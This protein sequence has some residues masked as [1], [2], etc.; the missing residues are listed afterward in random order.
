MQRGGR[1]QFPIWMGSRTFFAGKL[2]SDVGKEF[3]VWPKFQIQSIGQCQRWRITVSRDDKA[4]SSTVNLWTIWRSGRNKETRTVD[5]RREQSSRLAHAKLDC[6][7]F[8]PP[9]TQQNILVYNEWCFRLPVQSR[10]LW[11]PPTRAQCVA[12]RSL[13]GRGDLHL[14][15]NYEYAKHIHTWE[16]GRLDFKNLPRF[17]L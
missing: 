9:L 5:S 3:Y 14:K 4:G 7:L 10:R 6:R 13:L 11:C 12:E 15:G 17:F 2:N 1:D 8:D 16:G